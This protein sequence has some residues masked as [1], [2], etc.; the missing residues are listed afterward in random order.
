MYLHMYRIMYKGAVLKPGCAL[1][2]HKMF[3]SFVFE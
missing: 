3:K 2:L 1:C